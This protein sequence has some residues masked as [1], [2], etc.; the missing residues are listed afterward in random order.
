MPRRHVFLA[1]MGQFN[2]IRTA[3]ASMNIEQRLCLHRS[4]QMPLRLVRDDCGGAEAAD[5]AAKLVKELGEHKLS[6]RKLFCRRVFQSRQLKTFQLE[7]LANSA[8]LQACTVGA[9]MLPEEDPR[10]VRIP[11]CCKCGGRD[12]MYCQLGAIRNYCKVRFRHQNA[13]VS[14]Y[15][16][17]YGMQIFQKLPCKVSQILLARVAEFP[18]GTWLDGVEAEG[19][20]RKGC[21]RA[22]AGGATLC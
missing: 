12:D 2:A 21:R 4:I 18:R 14:P 10:V 3:G 6:D 17:L 8:R 16:A 7:T 13:V 19:E 1:Y 9:L 11:Y 20:G 22:K 5:M 15:Q